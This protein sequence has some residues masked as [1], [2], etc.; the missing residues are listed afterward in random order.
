MPLGGRESA[1]GQRPPSRA[2]RC[3]L[4]V[5]ALAA[6]TLAPRSWPVLSTL[7]ARSLRHGLAAVGVE[8]RDTP[9]DFEVDLADVRD[10]SPTLW[11]VFFEEVRVS[12]GV[13]GR[14]CVSAVAIVTHLKRL[15]ADQPCGRG[16][17]VR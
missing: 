16:R 14:R 13:G 1:G 4:A 8:L 11:G 12:C 9:P 5:A 15:L 3:V 7:L 6:Y 17:P 10:G 2:L